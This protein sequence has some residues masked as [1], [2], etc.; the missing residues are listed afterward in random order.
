MTYVGSGIKEPLDP[1]EMTMKRLVAFTAVAL[2]SVGL[3]SAGP[4]VPKDIGAGAKWF[5]H[6]NFEAIR[7]IKLVQDMK[8]QCPIHQQCQAKME[9]LAKK[10]GMNPME[11][12]LGATL[13]SDRYG[14][15][16]GVVL[17]YVKK[18]DRE[19]IV[20]I[21]REKH[22]N[23][24]TS[25]YG[26]RLLYNWTDGHHG[27]K[28]D[29]TGTFASDSL[30][31][32][33]ADAQQVKA[34]LDVLDGKKPGLAEDA[35]L[36][37][38]I[39][40]TALLSSRGIDVPEDYRKTTLCPVLHNCKAASAVWTEEAGQIT[41]KYEFTTESEE[42]AKNFKAI[43]EGLKAMG[44]LRY[45]DIPAVKKV[46]DGLECSA[47]G[48]SFTATFSMSTA[49]VEAAVKAVVEQKRTC[50]QPH[51]SEEKCKATKK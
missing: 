30:I 6:V 21:L 20:N 43:V 45:S 18:L 1:K 51:C 44:E 10:L 23:Y 4:L 34:A 37:K 15:Q 14:G 35:P 8:A 46:M 39:P 27:K 28:M 29:L 50:P 24:K 38:G 22:P 26:S 36:I 19:R 17:I 41:G 3:A 7:S 16:V 48:D 32:I 47:K 42:T 9:K 12:V 31:V 2:L 5:G 11:D 33:G 49:D 25:E 13:Y 40:S